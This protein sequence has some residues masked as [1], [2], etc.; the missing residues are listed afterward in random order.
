MDG[1]LYVCQTYKRGVNKFAL[2]SQCVKFIS[3]S[4]PLKPSNSILRPLKRAI[5]GFTMSWSKSFLFHRSE[6]FIPFGT[7]FTVTILSF[8][9]NFK[10]SVN[11]F[12]NNCFGS[13]RMKQV[14]VRCYIVLFDHQLVAKLKQISFSRRVKQFLFQWSIIVL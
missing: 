12:S 6:G 2:F 5:D 7:V 13:F 10:T 3:G 4:F 9:E 8:I 11:Q 14:E 1:L